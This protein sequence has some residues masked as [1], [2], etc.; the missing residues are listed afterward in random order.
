MQWLILRWRKK[1]EE[2]KEKRKKKRKKNLG[3]WWLTVR[4]MMVDLDVVIM[5]GG[6]KLQMSHKWW[7]IVDRMIGHRDCKWATSKGGWLH[8]A[9]RTSI[10]TLI[11]FPPQILPISHLDMAANPRRWFR[12]RKISWCPSHTAPNID[13]PGCPSNS[14]MDTRSSNLR[15]STRLCT[16]W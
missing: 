10:S 2:E 9:V 13:F 14:V 6:N 15:T 4:R 1:E 3:G 11:T 16:N 5:D 7:L 8:C 12:W